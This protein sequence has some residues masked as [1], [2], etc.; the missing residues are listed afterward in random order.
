M[1]S[2][3][4][5]SLTFYTVHIFNIA[6][7]SIII[8]LSS[9]LKSFYTCPN[10]VCVYGMFTTH[11]NR[12]MNFVNITSI[13]HLIFIFFC[14]VTFFMLG[15]YT[16]NKQTIYFTK[17]RKGKFGVIVLYSV[18]L[19][20]SGIIAGAL[21]SNDFVTRTTSTSPNGGKVNLLK[22]FAIIHVVTSGSVFGIESF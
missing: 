3:D 5:I 16:D 1:D 18:Q 2:S 9:S 20:L 12:L 14:F 17:K 13:V 4:L 7:A 10:D 6:T 22:V 11:L 15:K 8:W 21:L 19:F